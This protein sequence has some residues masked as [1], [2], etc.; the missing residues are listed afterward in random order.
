MGISHVFNVEDLAPYQGTFEPFVLHLGPSTG[1]LVPYTPL[2]SSPKG[3]IE[4][5]LDDEIVTS[6]HDDFCHCLV[7]WWG[8]LASDVTWICALMQDLLKGDLGGCIVGVEVDFKKCLYLCLCLGIVSLILLFLLLCT[9]ELPI[10]D[11]SQSPEDW[12]GFILNWLSWL[13]QQPTVEL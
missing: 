1:S 10:Q 9:W 13:A 2:P 11:D 6:S 12:V 3:E 8:R 5:I 4:G 7:Q